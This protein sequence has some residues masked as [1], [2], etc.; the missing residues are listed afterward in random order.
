LLS[1]YFTPFQHLITF[2]FHFIN[3]LEAFLFYSL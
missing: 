1:Y 2:F 3:K